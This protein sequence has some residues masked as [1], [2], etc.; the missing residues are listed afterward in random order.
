[1]PNVGISFD[2]DTKAVSKF[3]SRRAKASS[4]SSA[5]WARVEPALREKCFFSARVNDAEVVGKMR[6]LIGKAL[7]SSKRG[8]N[9][10]YVSQE[11]FISEMK[12]YLRGRGYATGGTALTDIT[13]R[14]RLGLIY[15]MNVEEAREYAKYVRGQDA[16][17][18][19][20]YPAQE[21]LRVESRRVPRTDWQTRWRAAGGKIYG[22]RMIALKSDPVWTNLSRFGRPY[23]PFD[24][25]SGMGV[26]DIDRDEAIELKLLPDDEPADEIPDLDP[27]IEVEV[28]LD[29]IPEDLREQIIKETP[30]AEI[31]GDKLVMRDKAPLPTWK[32][33]G[34][35]SAKIWK[36]TLSEKKVDENI[37][38]VRLDK[39]IKVIDPLNEEIL[40]SSK[41][42][43][44]LKNIDEKLP[45]DVIGRLRR[46]PIA[47]D[48]VAMATE[49]WELP[50][51]FRNYIA[52]YKK[53]SGGKKGVAVSQQGNEINTYLIEDVGE[54][55][56]FRKGKLIYESK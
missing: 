8:G 37:S 39:G 2:A 1:M 4:M 20:M 43:H 32:D 7:D 9:E 54:L 3:E 30:N 40:L 16:D 5:E 23:P 13:S 26:E 56:K 42:I 31:K 55:N 53:A 33:K 18:L 28:S 24:F 29:R 38:K 44:W 35:E 14:R 46:L 15:Q 27:A 6:E 51:G 19:D 21:F 25:G 52:V 10:A 49:I 11:K 17:A 48:C 41:K 47:E 36:P 45:N 50:N 22:G 12:N 34:M